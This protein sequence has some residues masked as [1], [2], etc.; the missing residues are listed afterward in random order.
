[1]GLEQLETLRRSLAMARPDGA[2]TAL[3][4]A[5]A[6]VL[7]E[8]VQRAD[9]LRTGLVDLL[10]G[11]RVTRENA[12]LRQVLSRLARLLAETGFADDN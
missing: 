6:V 7:V 2:A 12:H 4:N 1:M 10:T 3:T 8:R 11:T 9:K 5:D